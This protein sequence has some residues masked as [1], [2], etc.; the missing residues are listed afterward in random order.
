MS[1]FQKPI[2]K[3][4][5]NATL[6]IHP[7]RGGKS[8]PTTT[9]HRATFFFIFFAIDDFRSAW[10]HVR[11]VHVNL[12]FEL[13]NIDLINLEFNSTAWCCVWCCRFYSLEHHDVCAAWWMMMARADLGFLHYVLGFS[14]CPLHSTD[15]I[16]RNV[17]MNHRSTIHTNYN[18]VSPPCIMMHV[19]ANENGINNKNCNNSLWK[20]QRKDFL[21]FFLWRRRW[22][23]SV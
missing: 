10:M 19:P 12:D 3:W 7:G 8:A 5:D 22:C 4:G 17:F 21:L 18:T 2:M 20:K 23:Q 11:R 15:L 1:L 13:N 14:I 16:S 6:L 9:S